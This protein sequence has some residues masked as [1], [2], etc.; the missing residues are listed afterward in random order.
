MKREDNLFEKIVEP[1]NLR[2]AFWKARKA[3]DGKKE[4]IEFAKNLDKNL[5]NLRF[6]LLH[7]T[8]ELGD[9]HYFTIYDPKE[10]KICAANFKERVLHH[11]IMNICHDNFEKFQICNS[12]ASRLNKGTYAG[13]KKAAE[14]QKKYKWYLKL[15]IKKYFDTIDH[16]ILKSQ[17]C[18]R[19]K[20]KRLLSIFSQI[21]DS[22]KVESGT[23]VPIGNLTSQYFAN[24][25]LGYA[26]HF[27]KE[28]LNVPAYVRYM[29]DM[30]LWSND[31][32]GLLRNGRD[33]ESFL[34]DTLNLT[35]KLFCLNSVEKGLPFCGYNLFPHKTLLGN[36]SKKRFKSKLQHFNLK[37]NN[38]EWN[39]KEY[40]SH[41]LPLFAFVQ[42]A[43][44]FML[45]K[46]Q[47]K[48]IEN[49]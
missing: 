47:L 42:H 5:M 25:Y 2:L 12:Y 31:K 32:S 48:H 13:L 17:L 22:Y 49:G 8:L 45:R 6:E 38:Q 7:G 41:V 29:D 15:D 39:Q 44:T 33:F 10:R 23:G 18:R 35:L 16:K 40:Q 14:Y 28:I 43:D 3:K 4:V 36:N 27:V 21:I 34:N 11:A 30:I 20:D 24:H 1:E 37:L 46:N 9:Y 19:F 26:D